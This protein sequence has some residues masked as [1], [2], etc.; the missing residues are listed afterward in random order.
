MITA[1]DHSCG[2]IQ[3]NHTPARVMFAFQHHFDKQFILGNLH[4]SRHN[5]AKYFVGFCSN[6]KNTVVPNK[7]K[8][9][10]CV[11]DGTFRSGEF[12]ASVT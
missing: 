9:I 4:F 6:N 5:S 3:K 1:D 11:S 12:T 7:S 10:N 2:D 8:T